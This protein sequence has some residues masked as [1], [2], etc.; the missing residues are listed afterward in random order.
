MNNQLAD[1][2]LNFLL[3]LAR[4]PIFVFP[5]FL[6][7]LAVWRVA[8]LRPATPCHPFGINHENFQEKVIESVS[9]TV[10]ESINE[11]LLEP[12]LKNHHVE[13]PAGMSTYDLLD[14]HLLA[15]HGD[16]LAYLSDMFS[17]LSHLRANSP[18]FEQALTIIQKGVAF[19]EGGSRRGP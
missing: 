5:I 18:F 12:L 11:T 6:W 10:K 17:S 14:D 16:D 19:G 9:E 8:R 7:I 15:G 2:V 3:E 1:I 13:L 4:N